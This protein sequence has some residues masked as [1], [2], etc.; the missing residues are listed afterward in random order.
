M[1]DEVE[2]AVRNGSRDASATS[3]RTRPRAPAES[4]PRLLEHPRRR[5][6]RRRPPPPGTA[7]AI[8]NAPAPGARAEVERARGGGSSASSAASYGARCSADASAPSAARARRTARDQAA[9]EPPERGPAHDDVRREPREPPAER[10]RSSSQVGR[11]TRLGRPARA[12]NIAAALPPLIA[13]AMFRY[14]SSYRMMSPGRASA[15]VR[16]A[17][18]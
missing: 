17:T 6:R 2:R 18:A 9:E 8:A 11:R 15:N 7:R 4:A 5:D 16:A 14:A 1:R 12:A 3:K 13:I 10:R